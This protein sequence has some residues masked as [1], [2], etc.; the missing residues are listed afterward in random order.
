MGNDFNTPP[1][2]PPV[3]VA[4]VTAAIIGQL[5]LSSSRALI[6]EFARNA[7][8]PT[9]YPTRMLDFAFQRAANELIRKARLC[10]RTDLQDTVSAQGSYTV[11]PNTFRCERL[12]SAFLTGANVVVRR[13]CE[14]VGYLR[15]GPYVRGG[16]IFPNFQRSKTARLDIIDYT[17]LNDYVI[18]NQDNRQP[19][20]IAFQDDNIYTLWPTPDQTYTVNLR[21]ADFF[22]KWAL[23]IPTCTFTNTAGVLSNVVVTDGSDN[24]GA[25]MTAA[26]SDAGGGTGATATATLANGQLASVSVG[27]GGGSGYSSATKLL[28]NGQ[29]SAD[30]AFNL[31]DDLLYEV[32]ALGTPAFL[33]FNDP[34]HAYA[35]AK[36]QEFKAYIK[37]IAGRI[38]GL[39]VKKIV[40]R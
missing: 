13:D 23:G 8:D 30:V 26:F 6:R 24:F 2:T 31:P 14:D 18:A 34:E 25:S 7:G 5:L 3:G 10:L 32:M 37:E 21:W 35:T 28:L 1:A 22:T 29:D 11:L 12:D 15:G 20:A 40:R 38:G 33:Q 9:F 16:D 39:G 27:G 19:T 17:D 36:G 4:T